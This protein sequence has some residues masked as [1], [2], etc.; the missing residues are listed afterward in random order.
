MSWHGTVSE[1]A[2]SGRLRLARVGETLWCLIAENDS[3]NFRLI[4]TE[5]V[6]SES[7]L[8]GGIR[9]SAGVFSSGKTHGTTSVIWKDITIRAERITDWQAPDQASP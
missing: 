3:P 2:T 6:G 4:H 7:L 5:Q 9:L 8:F 1:E